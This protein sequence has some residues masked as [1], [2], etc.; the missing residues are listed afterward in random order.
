MLRALRA[1]MT[2]H[3]YSALPS[4]RTLLYAQLFLSDLCNSANSLW[5][6]NNE[7]KSSKVKCGSIKPSQVKGHKQIQTP[8][9][10]SPA[11]FVHVSL[12]VFA[13]KI[14]RMM[15]GAPCRGGR[16]ALQVWELLLL[17]QLLLLHLQLQLH[18]PAAGAIIMA[19][20]LV[21]NPMGRFFPKRQESIGNH[22][23]KNQ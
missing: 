19:V 21:R 14:P 12:F 20:A 18:L 8:T 7:V 9:N 4:T 11:F 5:N 17:P 15:R 3:R 6:S 23:V 22:W 16:R 13:W 10:N 2:A 1:T